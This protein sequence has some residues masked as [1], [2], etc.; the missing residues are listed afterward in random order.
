MGKIAVTTASGQLGQA[1]VHALARLDH[2]DQVI[3]LARTPANADT[4]DIE[5]RPGDYDRPDQLA[6]SLKDVDAL[7]LIS[8]N[9]DPTARIQQH[10]NAIAAAKAADVGKIVFTSVQ[11]IQDAPDRSVGAS[12]LQTEADLKNSGLARVIGRNGVYIEPD[13]EYIDTYAKDGAITNC[14]GDAGCGYTTRQEL[15]AAYAQMVSDDA[16]NAQTYNL[17][18]PPLTQADLARHLSHAFDVPLTYHAMSV[19]AYEQDRIAALGPDLGPIIAGIYA[20][21]RSGGLN[22]PSD[23]DR[24]AGRPHQTWDAYFDALKRAKHS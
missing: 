21:I 16:H 20:K 1:T 8:G 22:N 6:T 15:A 4:L 2:I 9:Q 19:A 7:V 12:F 17:N 11:G 23:F 13:V 10:R 24:A 18:G 5:I 14:A 3:G